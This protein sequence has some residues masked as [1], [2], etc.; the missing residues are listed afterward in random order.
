MPNRHVSKSEF[1]AK[2]LELFRQVESS[3]DRLIVTNHGR[4]TLEVRPYRDDAQGPLEILRG[5]H[6]RYENPT[7]PVGEDDWEAVK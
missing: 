7:D 1:K 2:A 3:G 4:P 6:L 5:S